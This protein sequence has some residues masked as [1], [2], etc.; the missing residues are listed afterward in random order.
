MNDLIL[1]QAIATGRLGKHPFYW[2]EAIDS[3]NARALEM[4]RNGVPDQT[5]VAAES[6]NR[7]RGRLGRAWVSPPGTGLYVSIVLRPQLEPEH[8]SQMTLMAGVAVCR[9]IDSEAGIFTR[10]KWPNDVLADG[11]KIAG[12][13]AES[14]GISSQRKTAVVLGIGINVET[15]PEAFPQ[16]LRSRAASIFAVTG[17]IVPKGALLKRLLA[18]INQLT[19]AL[20]GGGFAKILAEWKGRDATLGKRLNWIT[21]AQQVICGVAMGPDEKGHL[22]IKDSSGTVHE[23]VSG[24]INLLG[25]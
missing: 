2:Y 19:E 16:E 4:A 15:P 21:T 6:Q 25:S 8:L 12:I 23:V 24:D 11:K 20:E 1:Q 14:T 17:K 9:A 7:G 10:I 5:V 22:H 18:E 3:T 13:L